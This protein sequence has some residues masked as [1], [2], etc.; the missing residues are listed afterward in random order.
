MAETLQNFKKKKFNDTFD[1]KNVNNILYLVDN[2][3]RPVSTT[4][5]EQYGWQTSLRGDRKEFNQRKNS[6]KVK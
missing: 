4:C 3:A 6:K 1:E 2:D 5:Y